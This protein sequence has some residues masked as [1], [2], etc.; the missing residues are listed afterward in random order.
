VGKGRQIPIELYR[1]ENCGWGAKL[2]KSKSESNKKQRVK[3]GTFVGT[4]SGELIETSEA[5]R[6]DM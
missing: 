6:R 1:T 4:Y 2:A 5:R 3:A